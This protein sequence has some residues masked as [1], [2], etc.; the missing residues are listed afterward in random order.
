MDYM[1]RLAEERGDPLAP[2]DI[3]ILDSGVGTG[4]LLT[5]YI[6]RLSE[7]L[8]RKYNGRLPENVARDALRRI[9]RNMAGFD[10]DALAFMTARVNYLMTLQAQDFYRIRRV[11][12][13]RS[14]FT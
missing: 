13:L 3:R 5:R 14:L 9:T 1:L 7:Y 8:Y 2:L 4:T 6:Q 10:V 12:A 11:K